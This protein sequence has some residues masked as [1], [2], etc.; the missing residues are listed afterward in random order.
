MYSYLLP[1]EYPNVQYQRERQQPAE[2]APIVHRGQQA[3]TAQSTPT[4]NAYSWKLTGFTQCTHSCAGGNS[5][6]VLFAAMWLAVSFIFNLKN[7]YNHFIQSLCSRL[8][9]IGQSSVSF[10][11]PL[12]DNSVAKADPLTR[13]Q[14]MPQNHAK[15][16]SFTDIFAI[17]WVLQ[18]TMTFMQPEKWRH[19]RHWRLMG[20]SLRSLYT[21]EN[22]NIHF[23]ECI[24]ETLNGR[25]GT[26]LISS[27]GKRQKVPL[28]EHVVSHF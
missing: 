10:I 22:G 1:K 2:P 20:K 27:R 6:L 12:H 24:G 8:W 17:S 3:P 23:T 19:Q 4:R 11:N 9:R 15:D 14:Q 26:C 28:K 7:F 13:R 16:V 25:K 18:Q 21:E 5:L